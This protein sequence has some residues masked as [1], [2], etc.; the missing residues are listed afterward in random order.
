MKLHFYKFQGTGN[1]FIV[2]DNRKHEYNGLSTEQIKRICDRRFG[3]GADGLMLLQEKKSYDFEMKYYNA[4]GK[5]GSMCGNGGRCILKFAYQL[6][7]HRDVYKFLAVDGVHEGEIDTDGTVSLKMKDVKAIHKFHNDLILDTGSPHYI[8]IV[9]DVMNMD[10]FKK[11]YEIR[12]SKEFEEE[13]IN[14][15]FVE[16][17]E[18]VD[19]II[20]RTYERGVEDETFSCGT[21]VTAAALVC[22]HNDNGFND[23]EVR[24]LGGQLTVEFDRIDENHYE[25]IWLCGPAEKVYEGEIIV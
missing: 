13:G 20:V 2:A 10:V 11:G 5:E 16:Q 19:K 25:N 22:Y 23:V 6:G 17:T 18:D 1:D 7:I 8:K 21:G 12:H 15:N 4:D 3:I 14:V 24:T 9:T